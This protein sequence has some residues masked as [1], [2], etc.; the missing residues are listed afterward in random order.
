MPWRHR[1]S[2][3]EAGGRLDRFLETRLDGLSRSQIKKLADQG[4]LLVDGT[5]VKAGH[6]LKAGETIEVSVPP[7]PEPTPVPE[8]IPLVVVYEDDAVLVVDKP[9]GMSVHPGAGRPRGTLVN[10]LLGRGTP[11][12]G[13]GAPIRPG[14][15]HR[16][17]RGTSGLLVVAKTDCA[18]ER[19][20]KALARREV[21]RRYWAIVWGRPDPER[22]RISAALGR[23]R[24]DRRRMRVVARG[25]REAATRYQALWSDGTVSALALALETGRTH[26]IRV[27]LKHLGH[28]VFGDPDYGGRAGRHGAVPAD[29]LERVRAALAVLQRQA[30]HAA[31]LSFCHPV[32]GARL[33]FASEP[34]EDLKEAAARLGLPPS[35]L[36]VNAMEEP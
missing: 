2:T 31:T 30:L 17:D 28:P 24:A 15:V 20:S 5:P 23:S 7:P 10:A 35:A 4:L 6:P 14:I 16:L 29:A 32:T 36:S 13:L 3:A 27:H 33:A 11:L 19:L 18:H 1:V 8:A 26:Q 22:G 34:P 21:G 9:A 25:G 12:S